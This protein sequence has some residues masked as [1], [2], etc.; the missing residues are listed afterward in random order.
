MHEAAKC[1]QDVPQYVFP[2]DGWATLSHSEGKT[3][4]LC[5]QEREGAALGPC[6]HE[7][8]VGLERRKFIK[9]DNTNGEWK[10]LYKKQ[11]LNGHTK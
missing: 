7:D 11:S 10:H 8:S 4:Y 3:I 6:P 9:H 2:S 1:Y 5:G